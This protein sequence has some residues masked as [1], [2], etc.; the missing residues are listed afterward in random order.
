MVVAAMCFAAILTV[1]RQAAIEADIAEELSGPAARTLSVTDTSGEG[2]NAQACVDVLSGVSGVSAVIGRGIPTDVVN[3][4]LGDGA[5]KVAAVELLGPVETSVEITVGRAPRSGEIIVPEGMLDDLR[6]EEPAGYLEAADGRQ[7]SVVGAFR[8]KPAFEDLSSTAVAIQGRNYDTT[9]QQIT[10]VAESAESTA[11]V[12]D[13]ALAILDVDPETANISTPSAASSTVQSVTGELAGYGRELLFLIV[14][15]GAFFVAVVVLADVLIRQRDL[16]RRRT[17]GITRSALI[18]V[19]GLRTCAPAILGSLI[20]A[21]GGQIV[22]VVQN[23]PVPWDFIV[24]VPMLAV[25]TATLICLAPA[26]YAA[27]RDPVTV[28]RKP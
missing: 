10:V 2:L 22:M 12:R 28:M 27:N 9:I 17:L 1:G 24:A 6:L 25:I 15:V 26:S 14:G 20:G 16:G 13:T 7:W 18:A 5:S 11:A 3:G 4:A 21:A 23:N 8:P 19:V